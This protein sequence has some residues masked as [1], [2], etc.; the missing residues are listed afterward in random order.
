MKRL[1]APML[2]VENLWKVFGYN[3]QLKK[4]FEPK[5][6]KSITDRGGLIAVRNVSFS[7]MEGEVFVVMGL[8][9]SGKSTLARCL[10]RLLEPTSGRVSIGG[11]DVTS[12]NQ[13]Q[14]IEFRRTKV[15]MVFQHYGLLPHRTVL[16]NV[17]FGLK[18][19]G[20]D[21][22]TREDIGRELIEK[23]GLRGREKDFPHSL[24][25]GMQQRVGVARALAQNPDL[26]IMDEPFSGLDP[27]IRREMQDE[28]IRLQKE[29]N[30]T[31][32][33]VT[34]DLS[35]AMLLGDRMAVMKDGMFVQVG[36]PKE[37]VANPADDYVERFV[38]NER[39]NKTLTPA[40]A[41]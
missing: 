35:E 40:V 14:L 9:G 10:L 39:R 33:F 38:C 3:G 28:L 36:R 32:L 41:I 6:L 18:L 20:I 13:K 29:L 5:E 30:K 24:S 26:L 34:H 19:R 11:M 25:G 31:I 27:I 21:R 17:T 16:E 12:M 2:E 4:S 22:K 7:V 1:P 37:V 23:V 8:S 15:A